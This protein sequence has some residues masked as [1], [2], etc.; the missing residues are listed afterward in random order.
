MCVDESLIPFRG[1]VIFRQY[2]K[3]KQHKYGIKLFKLCSNPGYTVKVQ[4]YAGKNYDNVNTTPTNVV[5][6][7]CEGY[8]NKGHTVCT[9]NWYTSLD[10]AQKLLAGQTHLIGTLRKNRR[11]LPQIVVQRNLKAGEFS[12]QENADGIT[13]MKWKDKRD[14]LLLSTKHSVS[15]RR[16][17][18]KG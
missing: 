18:K 15:F 1:R 13:I 2:N 4:V 11:G 10:L 16:I 3:S 5:F 17:T 12:A 7:L 6:A 14:V 9:D 8:L